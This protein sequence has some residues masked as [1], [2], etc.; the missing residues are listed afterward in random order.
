MKKVF[1][2]VLSA[3]LMFSLAAC[4]GAA[5]GAA[6]GGSAAGTS[7]GGGAIKD[8]LTWVQGAD[9]TSMDPHVGKETPA[10]AVTRNI[11][12]TLVVIG[13]DS[14]PAPSLAKSWEQIDEITWK[15]TLR[16][17]VKFHDGSN[18]T[19]A[20]VKFS[21]E[22]AI[23]SPYVSYIVDFIDTVTADSDYE[24]TV[25]TKKP[26][27][28]ILANLAVPF[29]AIVPKAVVEADEEG[30]KL[31][32]IG[33]GPYKLAEW[34]QGE[35]VK[36]EANKDYFDG[37]PKSANLMMKVVPEAAQRTIALETGEADIAYDIAPNDLSKIR[38]N[39]DLSMLEAPSLSV[40][41]LGMNMNKETFGN[42]K[43]RQ[44]VRYA[45]D[46]QT[47]VDSILYGSGEVAHSLIPAQAFGFSQKSKVYELN[48]EKAKEL[49][50]EA[51]YPNGFDGVIMVNDNQ[52]RV[53]VC[54]VLQSQLKE[55]GINLEIKVMEFGSFIESTSAGE[56]DLALFGWTCSTAD[57][58][59]N[60]YSLL[61][62]SQ[63]GAPGNRSFVDDKE[64]DRL[65][66]AGRFTSDAAERQKFYDE[67]EVYLGDFTPYAPIYYTNV[68]VGTSA[69]VEG[70]VVD[71]NG[72]HLL[73]TAT[74][75]E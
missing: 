6:S 69:K 12:N 54:Q 40:F 70:F 48:I 43:V 28:P 66:E 35:Y 42:E 10:V 74:V 4:G 25:V 41:Y 5:S 75:S 26:Y 21:L 23:G 14:K 8:T 3:A 46:S 29:S 56:H 15:F 22:R 63:Q 55:I 51:G 24:V 53:E 32:P 73:S 62:S 17:D 50:K 71:P 38:D 65:V 39:A 44:A 72:Y 2:L 18:M 11:F 31:N 13:Q 20:D 37:A 68:N 16:D 34:K 7:E 36:M 61:H 1:A 58:D 49:M 33:T 9:V 30:F 19:A 47:L 59:Y 64:V 45:I 27:A 57:A 60:Y 52:T 67:L